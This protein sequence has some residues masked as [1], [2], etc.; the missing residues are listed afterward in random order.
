MLKPPI[1][2][3]DN[4]PDFYVYVWRRP[5]GEPFYV[6]KGRGRR[7]YDFYDRSDDFNEI[8][9]L[10]GC[11]VEIVRWFADEADAL[12]HEVE[13]IYQYGRRVFGG[14]L[15]N[16]TDGGDGCVGH[17]KSAESIAIWRSKNVGRKR[18]DDVRKRMSASKMG[19]EVSQ[20]TRA[21]LSAANKKL[22]EENPH[23]RT[24]RRLSMLNISDATRAKKSASHRKRFLDNPLER[25]RLAELMRGKP[26]PAERRAK[27]SATMS[28]V[29]KSADTVL[30]MQAAQRM[31]PPRGRYKGVSLDRGR[32][33]AIIFIDGK[34]RSLGYHDR[35]DQAAR[36][37]DDA[38]IKAWG[39]GMC[40]INFTS[41]DNDS[42]PQLSFAF[43]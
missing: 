26:V 9:A 12:N 40:Y 38:A 10:G 43:A 1:A 27:I 19:H 35:D 8:H 2:S 5:N 42:S 25:M 30:S 32:W 34:N 28:G 29:A 20:E 7:A 18:S 24:V 14:T 37:Y 22:F 16:K 41:P 11:T 36:A 33:R 39:E 4:K 6:G 23:L 15:V 17:V 13:L 21:K 31:K 3:N